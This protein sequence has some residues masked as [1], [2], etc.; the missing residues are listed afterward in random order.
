ME[1]FADD[2]RMIAAIQ[3]LGNSALDVTENTVKNRGAVRSL[4]PLEAGEFID[5]FRREAPRELL[6]MFSQK[7]DRKGIPAFEAGIALRRF[8]DADQHQRR[9]E[10]QRQKGIG[11]ESVRAAASIEC[12]NNGHAGGKMP[13]D[14]AQFLWI[15]GHAVAS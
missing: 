8:V 14:A 4:M 1:N 3:A 13:H 6:L 9:I 11:R 2:D 12:G 7:I 10:R 15:D 5:S